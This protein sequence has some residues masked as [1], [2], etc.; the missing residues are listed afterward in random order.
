MKLKDSSSPN[1]KT[2]A[3]Y[4]TFVRNYRFL[5]WYATIGSVVATIINDVLP[6]FIIAEALNKLQR[7]YANH[8]S[9]DFHA[10][11]PY[12]IA[13]CAAAII[14]S[15][16]LWQTQAR[17]AWLYMIKA[18]QKLMEHIFSHIQYMDT[19][20]HSDRFGGALVSQTNKFISAFERLHNDFNW[21]ILNG[22]TAFVASLV[23]LLFMNWVFALAFIGI[24]VVF[25]SVMYRRMEVQMPFNRRLSSTESQTTAKLA[26]TIT[27]VST[28]KAF[29]GEPFEDRLFHGQTGQAKQAYINLMNTQMKNEFI[30]RSGIAFVKVM[31]FSLGL[32]SIITLHYPIGAL[33]LTLTYTI[34]LTD[35]LWQFMFIVRNINRA[36]GD[37]TDMTEILGLEPAIQDPPDPQPVRIDRGGI[38]LKDV[39]FRYDDDKQNILFKHLDMDIKPGEQVGLVG[40]SGG[41]KSSLVRLLA[42]FMDVD[43]GAIEIDGQDIR[44]IRQSDLRKHLAYVPQEPLLFHRSLMENI[45][46]GRPE[47]GEDEVVAVAKLAH[48]HDFITSLP[49]GYGTLVGERGVKLSGGQRQRIAIARAMLKNAPIL[50]LDE[51]TSALDSQSELLIQDALWKLMEGRTAIVIAHRLSTIQRMDRIIVMEE[52]R[53]VEQGSHK[54]LLAKGGTYARL[55]EHQSGGFIE[56]DD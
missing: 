25:L 32:V 39:S 14:G 31:A 7:L 44:D 51:A 28:V 43:E 17:S 36:F 34:N 1:L 46:Y 42:R 3:I 8:Q 16:V 41:G 37:A 45:R 21:N 35:R 19:K 13:Y 12:F 10:L 33:Y 20:F 55:W 22:A 23:I 15:P 54:E 11:M 26:D 38:R 27:N 53:V 29:A 30:S 40:H 56:D 50:L 5:F 47:A 4:W 24:A 52:G 18:E 9:I 48:A 6:P 49:K 2:L